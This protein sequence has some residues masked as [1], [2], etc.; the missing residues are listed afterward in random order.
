MDQEEYQDYLVD[1]AKELLNA[2]LSDKE[3]RKKPEMKR[4]RNKRDE[5]VE[6]EA[7]SK[8]PFMWDPRETKHLVNNRKNMDNKDLKNFF[9]NETE[10]QKKLEDLDD[11][12]GFS[13]W[14]ERFLIQNQ[15]VKTPEEMADQ[16]DRDTEHVK[17]K[18]Y[19]LGIK[20][21]EL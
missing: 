5:K 2:E 8:I 16:L 17:M 1:K 15:S 20:V 14:E 12:K 18:M 10:F 9:E 19:M 4:K 3:E 7:G 21:D 11:W 13:R 6:K